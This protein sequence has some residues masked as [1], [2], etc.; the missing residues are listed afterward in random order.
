MAQSNLDRHAITTTVF[1]FTIVLVKSCFKK[2]V[3]L[4]G[5]CPEFPNSIDNFYF[6]QRKW[7]K[8]NDS[9]FKRISWVNLLVLGLTGNLV[10][11]LDWTLEIIECLCKRTILYTLQSYSSLYYY[12]KFLHFSFQSISCLN[13]H[14][15]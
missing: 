9:Q 11:Q 5:V 10:K 8:S 4:K 14:I 15:Y 12:T 13:C 7:A 1:Y 6:Y 2:C 3:Y